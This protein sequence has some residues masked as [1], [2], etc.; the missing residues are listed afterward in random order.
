M[1]KLFARLLARE[2]SFFLAS[3]ALVWQI[4]FLYVPIVVIIVASLLQ[5]VSIDFWHHLTLM[6]YR[7]VFDALHFSIIFRSLVLAI[8]N[9]IICLMFA[10]PVA[11]FLAVQAKSWKNILLILLILPFWTNFLV[12][13]YAWFSVIERKGFL[14][15]VLQKIGLIS[16]PIQIINTP[17]AIQL[18]MLFCY[19]PFMIMPI[20]TSLEKI[21]KRLLEAS[22]DLGANPWQ[23]FARITFPLSLTGVRTGFFL[24]FVP[25]F[26]EFVIPA[27]LGG[28]KTMYV[29]T[30]VSYYFVEGRDP[31]LGSAY[32]VVSAVVLILA[33][34]LITLFFK[35]LMNQSAAEGSKWR[36]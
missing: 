12:Q 13:V 21:N 28:G 6:N 24:V 8:S 23:T 3:P 32:T 31:F 19:L 20:Y 35:R 33:T 9:A 29:G 22:A 4:L 25:S 7:A 2:Q 1:K 36:I 18:V 14:N 26:G 15:I 27:L 5:D 10:Y 17:F 34:V 11:Y 30:A 16:E